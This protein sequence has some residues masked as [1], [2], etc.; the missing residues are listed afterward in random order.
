MPCLSQ[1]SFL[2]FG[3]WW[4]WLFPL[5]RS[6][7]QGQPQ[8]LASWCAAKEGYTLLAWHRFSWASHWPA[9]DFFVLHFFLFTKF[10]CLNLF[11]FLQHLF[12]LLTFA[13]MPAVWYPASLP[14]SPSLMREIC[15]LGAYI[16]WLQVWTCAH[17]LSAVDLMM[18]SFKFTVWGILSNWVFL[19]WRVG[20]SGL[21]LS[22]F[23]FRVVGCIWRRRLCARPCLW[24]NEPV[25]FWHDHVLWRFSADLGGGENKKEAEAWTLLAVARGN[26]WRATATEMSPGFWEQVES[27]VSFWEASWKECAAGSLEPLRAQ[28]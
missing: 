24:T 8:N 6:R 12:S 23:C 13:K 16:K 2:Y 27:G 21:G 5:L 7:H 14:P 28:S 18:R 22:G 15:Y 3:V 9:L 25:F 1:F 17:L 19:T 26:R 10:F 20:F 11:S 4:A